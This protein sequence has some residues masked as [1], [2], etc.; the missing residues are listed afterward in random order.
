VFCSA[1]VQHL[2]RK[3]GLDLAPGVTDKHTT[4]EDLERTTVPHATY[5]LQRELASGQRLEKSVPRGSKRG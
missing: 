2:F 1:L 4:P 5:L 3:T